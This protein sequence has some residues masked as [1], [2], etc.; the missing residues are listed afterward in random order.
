M[1]GGPRGPSRGASPAFLLTLLFAV[2]YA[3]FHVFQKK[4]I[5]SDTCYWIEYGLQIFRGDLGSF[6][7]SGDA[8]PFSPLVYAPGFPFLVGL[9]HLVF[10]NPVFCA[11]LVSLAASVLALRVIHD[12]ARELFGPAVGLIALLFA[13]VYTQLV[14][15][16]ASEHMVSSAILFLVL[17]VHTFILSLRREGA[18]YPLLA[19]A[20]GGLAVL[21]RFEFAF[22]MILFAAVYAWKAA[23]RTLPLRSPAVFGAALA[24]VYALYAVPLYRHSGFLLIPPSLGSKM[25]PAR[26]P[27]KPDFNAANYLRLNESGRTLLFNRNTASTATLAVQNRVRVS[28]EDWARFEEERRRNPAAGRGRLANYGIY[29][30]RH[31]PKLF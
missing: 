31:F 24:V 17:A 9:A 16:G 5:D 10:K 12:L 2:L 15:T 18:V 26:H 25:G 14:N 7:F 21:M 20:V 30:E 22:Y 27:D 13:G 3:V 28:D 29:F 1:T 4:L 8:P 23:R 11:H 19:G 6:H